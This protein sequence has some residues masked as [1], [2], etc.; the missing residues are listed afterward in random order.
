MQW[1]TINN[2]CIRITTM[3]QWK[4][5]KSLWTTMSMTNL[6][7]CVDFFKSVFVLSVSEVVVCATVRSN[8][9]GIMCWSNWN[10]NLTSFSLKI[11]KDP[12]R[13]SNIFRD[14]WRSSKKLEDPWR[15]LKILK[16]PQR[17]KKI[18]EV[19]KD[20]PKST[21]IKILKDPQTFSKILKDLERSLKI[22]KDP[23]SS[24]K[25]LTDP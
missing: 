14:P 25:M 11:L 7:V 5:Y 22:H 3:G 8:I 23:W 4:T 20:P 2:A 18:P 21:N 13:S 10:F 15:S 17:F 9:I 6:Q 16:V 24:W 19:L 1:I 12:W